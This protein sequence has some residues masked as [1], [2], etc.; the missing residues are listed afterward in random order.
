MAIPPLSG[1]FGVLTKSTRTAKCVIGPPSGDYGAYAYDDTISCHVETNCPNG[2]C[3]L[4]KVAKITVV[5]A[6]QLG[7][8]APV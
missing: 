1:D 8:V 5:E 6:Q 3:N 7:L 2:G 4:A